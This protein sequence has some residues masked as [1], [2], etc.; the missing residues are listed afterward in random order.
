M[1][2]NLKKMVE[3]NRPCNLVKYG[4]WAFIAGG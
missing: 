2:V 1:I 4:A 3:A